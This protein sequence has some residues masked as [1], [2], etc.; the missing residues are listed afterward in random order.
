MR[1][2]ISVLLFSGSLYLEHK[3]LF[4]TLLFVLLIECFVRIRPAIDVRVCKLPN[5]VNV[6]HS[7]PEDRY[8]SSFR[9]MG[10]VA[11]PNSLECYIRCRN[12]S[13]FISAFTNLS[14]SKSF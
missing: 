9:V 14:R 5:I 13:E 1:A 7:S 11:N 8:R 10:K 6:S 12:R 3:S 2:Y 4:E